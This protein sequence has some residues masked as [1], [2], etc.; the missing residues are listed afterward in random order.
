M[1]DKNTELRIWEGKNTKE[2]SNAKT[3]TCVQEER[4][5]KKVMR[6]IIT[7]SSISLIFCITVAI[8]NKMSSTPGSS[9]KKILTETK[10]KTLR[11]NVLARFWCARRVWLSCAGNGNHNS[12]LERPVKLF[13]ISSKVF[14]VC[15]QQALESRVCCLSFFSSFFSLPSSLF[16]PLLSLSALQSPHLILSLSLNTIIPMNERAGHGVQDSY[17][18]HEEAL[19]LSRSQ[20]R[21]GFRVYKA[22]S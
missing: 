18:Q 5:R 8:V 15:I 22:C 7:S 13:Q 16:F 11:I 4:K 1:K 12:V 2:H 19:C 10:I 20:W 21:R 17:I 3:K 9:K 6:I 14:R